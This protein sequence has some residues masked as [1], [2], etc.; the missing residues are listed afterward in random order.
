MAGRQGHVVPQMQGQAPPTPAECP[1]AGHMILDKSA[2]VAHLG[3]AAGRQREGAGCRG[4]SP[5]P[6][7]S[8]HASACKPKIKAVCPCSA[9]MAPAHRAACAGTQA[10]SA[11]CRHAPPSRAPALTASKGPLEPMSCMRTG[12]HGAFKGLGHGQPSTQ[13]NLHATAVSLPLPRTM[14][15]MG[16][17]LMTLTGI[18]KP[19]RPHLHELRIRVRHDPWDVVV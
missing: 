14:G 13:V 16:P 17:C 2:P 15:S 10:I 12:V 1:A 4:Y 18:P 7:S 11:I 19:T 3:A 8:L 6:S 5:A 9:A